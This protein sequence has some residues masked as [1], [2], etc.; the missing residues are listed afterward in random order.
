MISAILVSAVILTMSITAA[1]LSIHSTDESG[2]DRTR[3][4]VVNSAEAGI[5]AALSALQTTA[6]AQL[7]CS[8]QANLATSPNEQYTATITYYD[9][10][11][12]QMTCSNPG[13]SV[14]PTY[15]LITSSGGPSSS[16]ASPTATR[17]MQSFVTMHPVYG[18]FDSAIFSNSTPSTSNNLTVNGDFGDDADVYTNG[19]WS[20][21]NSMTVHGQMVSQGAITMTNTCQVTK[22]I[23]ANGAVSM[24][25]NTLAGHNVTSSTSS[26][27]LNNSAHILNNASA[28]TTISGGQIDGTRTPNHPQAAPPTKLLPTV[29]FSAPAW[30]GAGWAVQYQTCAQV[31]AV[32]TVSANTVYRISPTCSLSYSNNTTI[33]LSADMAI[34]TDGSI[35]MANKTTFQSADGNQHRLLFIMPTGT[36]CP[37]GNFSTSNNTSFVNLQ[38]FVYTPCNASFSN[39]ND[40]VGG[41]IYAGNVTISNQFSMNFL[42]LVIPG[43]GTV[44]GYKVD[45]SYVREI[46]NP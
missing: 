24:S 3:V 19:D 39:N 42:P 18:G 46:A 32:S 38:V 15:A 6:T 40:G 37:G 11:N 23:W 12:T 13:V 44:T 31:G 17:T 20:C 5:S 2:L 1:S 27:T 22:D 10:S 26:I 33:N 30:Q 9:S 43:A 35:S 7:P 29:T 8:L 36:A 34:V 41:Q 28:A 4:Q 25:N 14:M 21:G 45:I 16:G